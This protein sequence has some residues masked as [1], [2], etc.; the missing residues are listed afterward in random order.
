MLC[1]Y[2]GVS[3]CKEA[4]VSKQ[5]NW[6][7]NNIARVRPFFKRASLWAKNHPVLSIGAAF[8]LVL[9][10]IQI[11]MGYSSYQADE[12]ARARIFALRSTTLQEV[13]SSARQGKVVRI[14]DHYLRVGTLVSPRDETY[15]EI[16][17]K[18]G[19]HTKLLSSIG[20]GEDARKELTKVAVDKPII[21]EAG[22][23][24][25]RENRVFSLIQMVMLLVVIV[26]TL[27]A[28]QMLVGETVA[29]HSF[30]PQNRDEKL[31]LKDV[32]G[33]DDVKRE[34]TEIM[35][36]LMNAEV[37]AEHGVRAPRG[38]LFTGDPGVG[39]TMMAKAMANELKADFFYCTGADFAEMYVGVGPRRVRS[40]FRRARECR[41]AFI[42]IDEIDAL[43]SRVS[44]GNDSERLSTLN[45]MLSEL[46]GVN[47]N[48]QLLVVGATNFPDRLDPAL[49]RPGRF[50]RKV[51]IPL[52]DRT[53]R[54]D[55]LRLRLNGAAMDASVDLEA[56][57]DRTQGYS[58]AQL[59][60]L[61]DQARNL[62]LRDAG[63][64]P[65]KSSPSMTQEI[66]ERAQEI[67]MLGVS[68]NKL[69][70]EES[71]RAA[72]HE[73]GHALLGFL[74]C[75]DSYVEK[76]TILGRGGALGYTISRPKGERRLRTEDVLRGEISMLLAGRA[77]EQVLLKSVSSG[78]ADDLHR[79]NT[80]AREMV[81][82][83]GMGK[84]T[85]L[86]SFLDGGSSGASIPASMEADVRELLDS[87]Y[88][89]VLGVIASNRDW[90]TRQSGRLLSA[91]L[92]GHNAMFVVDPPL[93]ES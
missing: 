2:G 47:A 40:L 1:K 83:L 43:G 57:G 37:Y 64:S 46:D 52:P 18:S 72:I 31:G 24:A 56:L 68:E 4:E 58:G 59:V 77:A 9:L 6:I 12:A 76:V 65:S 33:Y 35:D 8:V 23:Q 28:A 82:F 21:F 36:Q 13:V 38:I 11:S 50:D 25:D 93:L 19:R 81:C 30:K 15:M 5:N 73:L 90:L 27:L 67:A 55:L 3:E 49:V 91:G 20:M 87:I 69:S 84:K 78:A 66:L 71:S 29:G 16:I 7:S 22:Y 89:D 75:P 53:T 32:V 63:G 42:F 41:R 88:L 74:R 86:L 14:V 61:V 44:M 10:V 85:G 39:K 34:M 62:A 51:H 26:L 70:A 92:L 17:E 60:A 79:A 80:L 45:Q 54:I 48:G